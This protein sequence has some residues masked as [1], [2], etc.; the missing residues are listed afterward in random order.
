MFCRRCSFWRSV[1]FG[2]LFPLWNLFRVL[3]SNDPWA[4]SL[5]YR[6][7]DLQWLLDVIARGLSEYDVAVKTRFNVEKKAAELFFASTGKVIAQIRLRNDYRGIEYLFL[8]ADLSEKSTVLIKQERP[9]ELI[10]RDLPG[11]R[12]TLRDLKDS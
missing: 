6:V 5:G 9:E 12:I 11:F 10:K 3:T 4:G 1:K 7:A 2:Y 8:Y